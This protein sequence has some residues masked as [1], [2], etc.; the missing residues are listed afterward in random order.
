MNC[1]LEFHIK[2]SR[3]FKCENVNAQYRTQD[4]FILWICVICWSIFADLVTAYDALLIYQMFSLF[5]LIRP[6]DY[7]TVSINLNF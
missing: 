7:L 6:L 5:K 1:N 4:I 3:P 2:I